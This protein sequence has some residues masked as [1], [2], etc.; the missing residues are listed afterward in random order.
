MI[1]SLGLSVLGDTMCR[2]T[3]EN[4]SSVHC[5]LYN[6]SLESIYKY[7]VSVSQVR[8]IQANHHSPLLITLG[9]RAAPGQVP[10]NHAS[11]FLVANWVFAFCLMST[12]GTKTRLGID[13]NANPREDLTKYGEAAVQ[14]GKITRRALEKLKRQE[15]DTPCLLRRYSVSRLVYSLLYSHIE[16]NSWSYLRSVAWWS[17]NISCFYGLVQASKKL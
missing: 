8:I 14:S 13:H 4:N 1:S 5:T 2:S 6:K 11:G 3:Q 15:R 9:L 12:R 10:A 16:S 7:L 17:G